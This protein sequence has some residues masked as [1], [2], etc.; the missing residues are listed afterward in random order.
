[1]IVLSTTKA[2]AV[3]LLVAAGS[4]TLLHGATQCHYFSRSYALAHGI[5]FWS[6]SSTFDD[7]CKADEQENRQPLAAPGACSSRFCMALLHCPCKSVLAN[8]AGTE[9]VPANHLL[10]CLALCKLYNDE[11]ISAMQVACT[12]G[13]LIH[14]KAAGI[15]R[16][17][18]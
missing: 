6:C 17:V 16:E 12:V 8:A 9:N 1:M 3:L 13:I 15:W 14:P 5:T 4:S 11:S 18:A 10:L 7:E 2:R